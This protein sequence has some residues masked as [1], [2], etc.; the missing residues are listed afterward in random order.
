MIC[1][2]PGRVTPYRCVLETGHAGN[3]VMM[4]PEGHQSAAEPMVALARTETASKSKR[5]TGQHS[6]SGGKR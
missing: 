6:A 4:V 3:H 2:H 1:N 5:R